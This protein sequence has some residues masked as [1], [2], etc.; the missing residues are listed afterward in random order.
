MSSTSSVMS[1]RSRSTPTATFRDIAQPTSPRV[2]DRLKLN[3]S[4]SGFPPAAIRTAISC[5][6]QPSSLPAIVR[7]SSRVH[8]NSARGS[9][10]TNRTARCCSSAGSRAV[11]RCNSSSVASAIGSN[12]NRM[13]SSSSMP[14]KTGT[15]GRKL[16]PSAPSVSARKVALQI[17][18]LAATIAMRCSMKPGRSR[19]SLSP[20]K[21]LSFF[22]V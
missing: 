6:R 9:W 22:R 1:S 2:C 17:P 21:S 11:A 10:R 3:P 12:A 15:A 18:T 8:T 5:G 14:G 13:T 19:P 7:K 4:H 16:I 20:C